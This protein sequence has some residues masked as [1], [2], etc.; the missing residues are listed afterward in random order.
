[1]PS[2]PPTTTPAEASKPLFW[3][4]DV[5]GTNIKFGLVDDS[6]KTL[7]FDHIPTQESE[8]P[9]AAVDRT[10]AVLAKVQRDLG[11]SNADVPMI[12]LGTPGSM[13]IP[14]GYLLDP[15]NL[16]HWWN[17]PIRDAFA[18]AT[19][20]PVAFIN[21]ANAAAY[22]EFWVGTGQRQDSMVLLTLGT[23]V[24]GG[25]VVADELI[26]GANS[27]GGECGHLIVDPSPTARLCVWGGG[28]GQL[29]AYASA[30]AVVDRTRERLTAGGTSSLSGLLGGSNSELSAK[31]VYLAAEQGDAM[32]LEI[33]DETAFWLGIG[34][35]SIVHVI[36]PGLV[37]LGGAMD[38]GGET[39]PVGQR[40]LEGIRKEFHARTF[41]HVAKGTE[42][43]FA[44]LG[45]DAGYLG[46]AG[47]ARKVYSKRMP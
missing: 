30:S 13:D 40:F 38:F 2:S 41:A 8:G 9:Q 44:S 27:F 25:V 33:V 28:R 15:P 21:D 35:T 18:Q 17:F 7:H 22:G 31:A 12:G 34:I 37:V 4:V 5:G 43:G 16:P 26:D 10:A 45:G 32:A 1:M 46:S 23:G 3:G 19:Q 11:F 42:I 6:G 14:R 47:F 24:G 36:D 20:R 29:E 39:S